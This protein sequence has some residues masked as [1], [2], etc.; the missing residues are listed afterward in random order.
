MAVQART[1]GAVS[2]ARP[3]TMR[4]GRLSE[5]IAGICVGKAG[6]ETLLKASAAEHPF[7]DLITGFPRLLAKGRQSRVKGAAKMTGD[8]QCS[9][10]F[11]I[12]LSGIIFTAAPGTTPAAPILPL[13]AAATAG[14]D[15]LTDVQWGR[16]CWRDRWG[17]V[18]C[19]GGW[20]G[21]WA[22]AGAVAGVATAG[23]TAG[24][25]CIAEGG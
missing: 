20:E 19:R 4:P 18:R 9:V 12:G 5:I 24:A 15:N 11:A 3:A 1:P 14:L 16:R 22:A 13:S 6:A 8:T 25:V 10:M 2:L 21:G 23:V 7:M 17:R